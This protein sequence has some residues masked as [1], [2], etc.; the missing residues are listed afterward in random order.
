[1]SN[2]NFTW[3]EAWYQK[4]CNGEWEHQSGITIETVDNPGWHVAID[5]NGTRYA[6]LPN[7]E[8]L[9]ESNGDSNWIRCNCVEGVFQGYG[10]PWK[11]GQ[12]VQ[13]FRSW[14]DNF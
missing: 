10:D 6:A 12:I 5:L 11:L 14:I 8:I 1:M 7:Y 2:D 3:L 13:T 4:Q 9:N